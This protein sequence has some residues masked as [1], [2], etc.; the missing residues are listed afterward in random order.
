MTHSMKRRRIVAA[1]A[2]GAAVAASLTALPATASTSCNYN[3]ITIN[4]GEGA[5]PPSAAIG[6]THFTGN[7]YIAFTAGSTWH[8]WADNNGGWDGDTWDTFYA[9]RTCN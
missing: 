5:E 2:V 4:V 1:L 6:H 7:H 3:A 8:Y 9:T